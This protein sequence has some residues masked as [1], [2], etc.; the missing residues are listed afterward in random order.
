MLDTCTLHDD[1]AALGFLLEPEEVYADYPTD[2]DIA[3]R[4]RWND[5]HNANWWL[6]NDTAMFE[7]CA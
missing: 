6:Y 3:E 1:W 5:W 4:Q 7:E 2:E